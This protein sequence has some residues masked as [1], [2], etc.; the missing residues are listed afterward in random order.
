MLKFAL[1][2]N[3]NCGKTTLFNTLTGSTAHVGNWPGVTV[4]KREGVYK[5]LSEHINIVDLPGIYSLSPYTPEEVVSR[6]FI[7]EEKPDCVINIVDATNLERNLYLTTQI[8]EIDVPVVVALNMIDVVKKSGDKLDAK[9]LEREI[10]V[11]VVEISALK[12]EGVKELME[13]ALEAAKQKRDG[14][15]VLAGTPLDHVISDVRIALKGK[16][17]DNPLFHAVK[18]TEGDE[19]EVASH[20]EEMRMVEEFKA[21][22]KDDVF[23]GDFEAMVADERYKYISTHFS[24][25]LTRV[26]KKE[27]LSKSDKADKV[28]THRIW[29]IPIFLVILFAVFHLTFGT[30]LLYLNAIFGFANDVNTGNGVLDAFVTVFYSSE[31]IST[32]GAIVFNLMGFITDQIGGGIALGMENAGAAEWAQGLVNDGI[33][34]GLSGILSFIPQILVLFLFIS[35]LEDSGYMARVA[36]ILDRAFRK[37]GLSGRAFIP[38]IMGFGCSVPAAINTR[39][40]ADEKERIMTNRVIP[41]FTCGAKAPILAAVCGALAAHYTNLDGGLLT[42]ALYVFGM[43][44]AVVTVAF[45]RQTSMR[46]EV[47]PFIMELPA[48]HAPQFR[49]LMLHLWDK[50]KHYIKKAF[51]I[52]LASSIVIWFLSNFS[53]SWQLVGIEDSILYNI[54]TFVQ[55]ICTPMGFGLQLGKFGWV[56]VVAAV[57]GLIAKENVIT[58]FYVLVPAIGAVLPDWDDGESGIGAV[59]ALMESTGVTWQGLIAFCVFNM[60]TIPCFAAA[61]A[62]RGETPKGKFKNTVAFWMITSYLTATIVYTVLSWWWTAFILVALIALVVIFFVFRNK[63]MIRWGKKSKQ[64]NE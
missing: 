15:T 35:I 63:G 10:G 16:G 51:T 58:T 60:L 36:F 52:I 57:T 6:N 37:F 27:N 31:G 18:L 7:L 25:A 38:M 33:W 59:M 62:V 3:P 17:V 1:A 56:F 41:F 12:E 55:W 45:M 24:G 64:R 49:N 14:K 28:L 30:D 5:K 48:Y 39:T 32:P 11:P 21:Q 26:P 34:G 50:L 20:P 13:R 47:P 54:G 42:F 43:V 9:K 40:L 53:W 61:A 29:G 44:M 19:L 46:G 23:E 22:F 2:G 4:D 8:M